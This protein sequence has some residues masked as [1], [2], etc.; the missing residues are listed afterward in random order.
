MIDE[1]IAQLRTVP[2]LKLVGGAVD[3]QAA[4]EEEPTITPAAFVIPLEENPG[5][6]ELGNFVMQRVAVA[7]GVVLVVRN[8]TDTKGAAATVDMEALRQSTKAVLL[9]FAP[10]DACDPLER[11]QSALLAFKEG[12]MWWQDIYITAYYDRSVL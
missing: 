12:H 5:A 7:V 2:A 11:G 10:N 6:N 3:L 9:G 8:L 4:A 1:L